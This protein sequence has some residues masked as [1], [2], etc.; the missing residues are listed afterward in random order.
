MTT[1]KQTALIYLRWMIVSD[2][3]EVLAIE[4]F[5]G[6]FQWNEEILKH[7]LRQPNVIGMVAEHGEKVVGFM[8]YALEKSSLTFLNFGVHPQ[9]R[10]L[11]V[12][13]Q[14]IEKLVVKLSSHRRTKIVLNAHEAN[15]TLQVFLRA[16]GFRSE[17]ICGEFYVMVRRFA[18]DVADVPVNRIAAYLEDS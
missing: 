3:E 18:E 16:T 1:K 2:C 12:G 6:D 17:G 9:W 13:R 15:L 11:G 5:N 14:M 7:H 10:R 4:S 8:V